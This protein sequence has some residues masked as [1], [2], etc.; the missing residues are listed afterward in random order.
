MRR[1]TST[2]LV[3]TLIATVALSAFTSIFVLSQKRASTSV[4]GLDRIIDYVHEHEVT[5]LATIIHGGLVL[6]K[7]LGSKPVELEYL[8]VLDDVVKIIKLSSRDP[9]RSLGVDA[10]CSYHVGRGSLLLAITKSGVLLFPE[11]IE[12]EAPPSEA[13]VIIPIVFS[14]RN[15][16]ELGK[17]FDIDPEL[18]AKPYPGGSG[19]RGINGTH[20]LILPRGREDEYFNENVTTACKGSKDNRVPFGVL[21]VGYDPS[22]L[23][24]RLSNPATPPRFS[25]LLAGPKMTGQ[26]KLCT[27]KNVLPLTQQGFRVK[28]HNFTGTI[29]IFDD[30]GNVMACSS[31]YPGVCG[32]IASAVGVWYYGTVLNWSV[33]I[34]GIA[35]YL[36]YYQRAPSGRGQSSSYEP[37][38]F[39]GDI[40]GNGVVDIIFITE[41]AYYGSSSKINDAKNV[42]EK[43]LVDYSTEPLKLV[44]L[45][46][47]YE[48]GSPD[49]SIDGS[50]YAGIALYLNLIFHDNSHPDENQLEDID[51]TDW[52][53][54][55][56]LV[57]ERGNEYIIR[58]YRY[59]EI[60][61]YHQTLVT[62]TDRSKYFTKVSQ[63]VYIPIPSSGKYWVVIAIQDPY[64]YEYYY[65]NRKYYYKNDADITVGIEI[66][67]VVPFM[68]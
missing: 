52:V 7:N 65:Y 43:Y 6:L 57:D 11:R 12:L 53:L 58:E 39:L 29:R 19:K 51:R 4:A 9:C 67:G 24:E 5:R 14:F 1:A 8:V 28:I 49:G 44:L 22:W 17:E 33:Y 27:S 60:C 13:T 18:I 26:E 50:K 48:L 31:S 21:V 3:A 56:L 20:V 40:D 15:L 42:D 36:G 47:G 23:K 25:I 66:I 35:G 63:S 34:D 37:Y 41:D 30:R 45:R 64:N 16:D 32:N 68:R 62:N 38:I 2:L 10:E 54:R 55:I 46:V 61:N 59:Q